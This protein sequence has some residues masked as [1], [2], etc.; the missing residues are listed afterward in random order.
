M[1]TSDFFNYIFTVQIVSYKMTVLM[2]E[3]LICPVIKS[4]RK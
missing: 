2:I 4:D 1:L 3:Y